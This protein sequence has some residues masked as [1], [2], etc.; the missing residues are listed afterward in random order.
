V[1]KVELEFYL[2]RGVIDL[3]SIEDDAIRR[4]ILKVKSLVKNAEFETAIGNLPPLF[5]EWVWS[6]VDG[7]PEEYF[8]DIEDINVVLSTSNSRIRL[9]L[10]DDN[11]IISINVSFAVSLKDTVE[12]DELQEWL[13]ASSMM[14]AG[15]VSGGWSYIKDEGCGVCVV[16]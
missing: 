1:S 3:E 13:D 14:Y 8:S 7:D 9:G 12:A 15:F 6:N 10:S 2:K 4:A 5:F 16:P 11:L